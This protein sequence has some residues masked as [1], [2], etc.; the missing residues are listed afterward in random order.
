MEKLI[1]FTRY[2]EPGT[3]KTRM[4][5][6]LGAEKA[7][8]LQR[9]MTE[10][11]LKQVSQ[12]LREPN[13]LIEIHFAGSDQQLMEQW[14][15]SNWVYQPQKKG[16]LG[17]KMSTAFDVLGEEGIRSVVI[18]GI[19]CPDINSSV[20]NQA[21]IALH[22]HDL[23]L[24]PA[25]DGGYYLIGLSRFIPEL[26][27]DIAWGSSYVLSQTQ[28]IAQQLNLT[29]AYLTTLADVDRPEDL[30]IWEKYHHLP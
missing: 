8:Q 24:G 12:V 15:G 22:N 1:I 28:T 25:E 21:F 20:I 23:V 14:L 17:E 11:T 19:D 27:K 9:L 13:V 2:P 10:H 7:A 18:I 16:D 30:P 29:I 5:P 3:T 4:I 26:F 6:L